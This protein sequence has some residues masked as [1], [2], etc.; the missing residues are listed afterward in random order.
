MDLGRRAIGRALVMLP[1][2]LLVL[3]A[4]AGCTSTQLTAGHRAANAGEV[5]SLDPFSSCAG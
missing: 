1:S 3:L 4:A 5:P 2:S